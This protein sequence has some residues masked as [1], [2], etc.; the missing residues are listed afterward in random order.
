MC[1]LSRGGLEAD[2]ASGLEEIVGVDVF[3]NG[4]KEVTLV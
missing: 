2:V 4:E 1:P 3:N